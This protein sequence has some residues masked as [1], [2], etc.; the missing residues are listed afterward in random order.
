MWLKRTQM[1]TS[2]SKSIREDIHRELFGLRAQAKH[3]QGMGVT[4]GEAG[5]LGKK[6][7]RQQAASEDFSVL[8][9]CAYMSQHEHGASGD[10]SQEVILSFHHVW[11]P[12]INLRVVMVE[13]K[14][15]YPRAGSCF[16]LL[17]QGLPL[18]SLTRQG[19]LARNSE[20][21]PCLWLP[22]TGITT[23]CY[24]TCHVT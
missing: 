24:D 12:G 8:C 16:A 17:A 5:A 3:R 23:I 9:V 22:S 14:S 10:N 4:S 13:S 21:S 18:G 20:G 7:D 1:V 6:E 2:S 11:T 19:C 15:L